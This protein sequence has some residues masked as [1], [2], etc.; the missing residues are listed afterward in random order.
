MKG[1]QQDMSALL[2]SQL[3]SFRRF[4]QEQSRSWES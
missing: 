2:P 3:A 4:A 1:W